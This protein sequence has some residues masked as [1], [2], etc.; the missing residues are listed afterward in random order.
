MKIKVG[1]VDA[2]EFDP[3][4]LADLSDVVT[5]HLHQTGNTDPDFVEI[6]RDDGTVPKHTR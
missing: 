4:E 6:Q 1:G 3:M 5:E 2:A